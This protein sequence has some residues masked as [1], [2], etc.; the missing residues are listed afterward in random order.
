MLPNDLKTDRHDNSF[1]FL[2][3]T[4]ML[5]INVRN[6]CSQVGEDVFPKMSEVSPATFPLRFRT[7]STILPTAVV[8]PFQRLFSPAE[9]ILGKWST[10]SSMSIKVYAQHKCLP[11]SFQILKLLR[12]EG[13]AEKIKK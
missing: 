8:S 11:F 1:S 3:I 12:L 13:R 2:S 5:F 10:F 4:E 6:L 9:T 7:K